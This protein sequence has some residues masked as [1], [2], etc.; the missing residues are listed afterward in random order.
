MK[1]RRFV[2]KHRCEHHVRERDRVFTFAA[3]VGQL[4]DFW[5]F[6]R[7]HTNASTRPASLR[8]GFGGSS[9]RISSLDIQW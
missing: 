9:V 1:D 4:R 6:N 3:Q 8:V 7:V 2:A 5:N